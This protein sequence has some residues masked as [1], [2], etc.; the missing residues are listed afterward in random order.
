M[1]KLT[2]LVIIFSFITFL[3]YKK[4]GT[5]IKSSPSVEKKAIFISYLEYQSL[6]ANKSILKQKEEIIK[7]IDN[8]KSLDLNML[9]IQVRSFCDSIY[10][11]KIYPFSSVFTGV[12]LESYPF[13]YLDFIIKIAKE[14]G[15]EV[16]AWINPYRIRNK[17]DI[18]SISKYSPAFLYLNTNH[19]KVIKDKGIYFN[20]ASKVVETLILDGIKELI[21][22]YKIDGLLL[23]DYFYPD[24]TID[25]ENY[26]LA[27]TN[28]TIDEYRFNNIN[29]LVKKIYRLT[30]TNNIKLSISLEGNIENNYLF[31]YADLKKWLSEEGY[32]DYVMPQIYFG[33]NNERKPYLETVKIWNDLIKI[34]SIKLIPAISSYKIGQEDINALGG[35]DEWLNNNDILMKQVLVSRNLSNYIGF[36]IFRY[37]YLFNDKYKTINTFNELNNLKA[38]L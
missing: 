27:N 22:N 6:L 35:K 9:I 24:K 31:N 10:P 16:H 21:A 37:E 25:L 12:E 17:T 29:Q 4:P 28:M 14:K 36:S 7:I 5:V 11:S 3:V 38:I 19:V 34:K 30:K 32:L 2:V 1:R 15:I 26:K 8:I 20:P 33:F 13:D 18:S 23:D